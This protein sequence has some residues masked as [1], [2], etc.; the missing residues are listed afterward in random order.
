MEDWTQKTDEQVFGKVGEQLGSE[1]SYWRQVEIHRR[2][3]LLAKSGAE[4]QVRAALAAEA[5]MDA[6]VRAAVASERSAVASERSAAAA[7]KSARWTKGS[8]IAMYLTVVATL[9]AAYLW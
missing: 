4:A 8:A 6:Q 7:E 9:A 2:N 5:A 1:G 3:Y